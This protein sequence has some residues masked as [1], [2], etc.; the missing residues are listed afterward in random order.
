[1]PGM[2]FGMGM[3]MGCGCSGCCDKPPTSTTTTTTSHKPTLA[4]GVPPITPGISSFLKFNFPAPIVPP[5]SSLHVAKSVT[6][7]AVMLANEEPLNTSPIPFLKDDQG[8]K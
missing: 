5:H 2:G 1:M 6:F 7:P 3:G 4:P 8:R